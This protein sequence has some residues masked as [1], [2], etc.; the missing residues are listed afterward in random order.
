MASKVISGDIPK[1]E[2][3]MP[4]Q[5][6]GG[7]VAPSH[8]SL[9]YNTPQPSARQV[10]PDGEEQMQMQAQKTLAEAERGRLVREGREEGRREGEAA[11]RRA[12]QAELQPVLQKLASSIQQ[13]SELPGRLRAQAETQLVELAMAIA[14]R[15]L[16][17]ELT[18]DPTVI[19]GLVRVGLDK[20]RVQDVQ[21]VRVCPEHQAAIKEWLTRSGAENVEVSADPTLERGGVILETSRG[22]LDVSIGTQLREIERGFTDRMRGQG[23]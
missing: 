6:V 1:I 5:M 18:V 16:Q 8:Y 23:Y 20:V 15:I 9:Q 19:T 3:P 7:P 17:R 13:V 21:R 22:K 11:G 10:V 12:A 14:Q 4:W 2:Q